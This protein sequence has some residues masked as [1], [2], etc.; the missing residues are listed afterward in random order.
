MVH[1]PMLERGLQLPSGSHA[2]AIL[3]ARRH[4]NEHVVW[5]VDVAALAPVALEVEGNVLE[6]AIFKHK[7]RSVIERSQDMDKLFASHD[8]CN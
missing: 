7:L 8:F 6:T 3:S 5:R 2:V 4:G 1:L